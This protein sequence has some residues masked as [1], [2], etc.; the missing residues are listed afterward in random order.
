MHSRR[1]SCAM[2][3]GVL[4]LLLIAGASAGKWAGRELLILDEA[5]RTSLY[6]NALKKR[7]NQVLESAQKTLKAATNS[8]FETC[9]PGDLRYLRE[10]LFGAP[11]VKEISRLTDSRLVC[12]T[13][14]GAVEL[15]VQREVAR[16]ALTDDTFVKVNGGVVTVGGRPSRWGNSY[17]ELILNPAAFQQFDS[18]HYDYTVFVRDRDGQKAVSLYSNPS[19]QAA[20]FVFAPALINGN[21]IANNGQSTCDALTGICVLIS[22][23]SHESATLARWTLLLTISVGTLAGGFL[24][25]GWLY[26]HQRERSLHSKLKKALIAKELHLCYQPMVDIASGQLIGF[27]ALLRWQLRKGEFVPPDI[28]VAE[29]ETYGLAEMITLYVIDRVIDDMANTLNDRRDITIN[30]NLSPS[31]LANGEFMDQL[32]SKLT[33]ADIDARQ[34]CLELTERTPVDFRKATEG[35][36]RLRARG[37]RIFIDDFGT[38]YCG[39]SYLSEMRVDAIKIDKIFTRSIG[40]DGERIP[41]VKQIISLAREHEVDIVIEGVETDAQLSYF[42]SLQTPL[43][44]QGWLFGAPMEAVDARLLI[45]NTGNVT[46]ASTGRHRCSFT[47]PAEIESLVTKIPPSG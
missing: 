12:S 24:G 47:S 16:I 31:N 25:L 20:E 14:F 37:H 23:K 11:Q 5:Q 41:I 44:G 19:S 30:I 2:V 28:F 15:Q 27:E 35:I 42:H 21:Y 9:S 8:P 4:L 17:T 46:E 38:G 45:G 22:L 26:Y 40:N 36:K 13:T 6:M 32:E 3:P 7:A 18:S 29:A 1:V 43:V 10:I 33:A 39:L 34:L